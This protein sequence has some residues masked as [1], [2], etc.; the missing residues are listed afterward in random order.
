MVLTRKIEEISFKDERG[1]Y[2]D[3]VVHE[4]YIEIAIND[5]KEDRMG[6]TLEDWKYLDKEIRRIF[7]DMNKENKEE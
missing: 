4:G 2:F 5:S 7:K 1:N 6:L 3:V